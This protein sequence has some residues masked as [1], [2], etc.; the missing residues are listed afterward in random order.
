MHTLCKLNPIMHKVVFIVDFICICLIKM[1]EMRTKRE[2]EYGQFL[3]T[4]KFKS[5]IFCYTVLRVIYPIVE[6]WE[7]VVFICT[8]FVQI[9]VRHVVRSGRV[10]GSVLQIDV[11]MYDFA[12]YP[13]Y[14]R[15]MVITIGLIFEEM[16]G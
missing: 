5:T 16:H 4:A 12:I 10:L 6:I 1:L 2:L 13:K 7:L 11:I 15:F 3:S 9:L 8:S 14:R